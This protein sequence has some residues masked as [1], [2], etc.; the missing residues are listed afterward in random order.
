MIKIDN[1]TSIQSL[2]AA[3]NE[4]SKNNSIDISISKGLSSADISLIPASIQFFATWYD[5]T[6]S[7]KI[8]F[9]LKSEKDLAEFYEYDYLFPS[10]AY[11]WN[12]EMVD[13]NGNDLKHLLKVE[14]RT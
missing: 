1:K 6:Q 10:V 5:L 11:C 2:E 9:N 3:Y 7:G 12:R 8:I 4:L 13:T 14:N